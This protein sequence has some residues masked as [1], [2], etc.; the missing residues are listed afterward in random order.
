MKK[1]A[2]ILI[3]GILLFNWT[4]Y[5]LLT[6]YLE[7]RANI[8]LEAQLDNNNYNQ[9]DLI[10]IKI[11]STLPY[12]INSKEY[13]RVD[14]EIEIEGK[15]YNY[16]KRRLYNDSLEYLCIPNEAKMKLGNARDEFF[17]F[18]NDL[19]HSNSGKKQG[20]NSLFGKNLLSE[21]CQ[22][23]DA[24]VFPAYSLDLHTN[25]YYYLAGLSQALLSPQEQPPDTCC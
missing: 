9:S 14:G 10:S 15:H 22:A 7:D 1:T 13:D 4:G 19:Q 12:Y 11:P 20:S 6:S 18:V 8:A 21:Y 25:S 2:A 24:W 3:L 16:V 23:T 17:K 5:R